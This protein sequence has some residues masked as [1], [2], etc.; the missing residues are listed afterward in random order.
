MEFQEPQNQS[1][2]KMQVHD[3]ITGS[4]TTQAFPVPFQRLEK[5]VIVRLVNTRF[6][7]YHQIQPFELLLVMAETFPQQALDSIAIYR[8]ANMLFCYRQPQTSLLPVLIM[9]RKHSEIPIC[10]SNGLRKNLF[11]V[12]CRE[13]AY[14]ARKPQL[15]NRLLTQGVRRV[16]P[17]AR[18]AL[19]T[20]RPPLVAM[21]A[22]KPWVRARLRLLG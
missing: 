7:Q 2:R 4:L 3:L 8:P 22:R 15:R 1:G 13:Q 9:L 20:L 12:L 10:R 16:R 14:M 6:Y 11:V 18:R 5:R 19:I 21:R 17:L